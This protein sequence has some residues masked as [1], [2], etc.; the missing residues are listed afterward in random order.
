[1]VKLRKNA[2][3]Y[4]LNIR[5]IYPRVKS[6]IVSFPLDK[7]LFNAISDTCAQYFIYFKLFGVIRLSQARNCKTGLQ[8]DDPVSLTV[9]KQVEARVEQ[10][11][12]HEIFPSKSFVN[13]PWRA[14]LSLW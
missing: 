11:S 10:L 4:F 2:P 8:W 13:T 5:G 14:S 6:F 1:M 12:L 7:K 9:H 3:L